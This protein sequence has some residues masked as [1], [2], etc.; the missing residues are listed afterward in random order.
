[1]LVGT[2]EEELPEEILLEIFRFLDEIDL[3]GISMVCKRWSILSKSNLLWTDVLIKNQLLLYPVNNNNFSKDYFEDYIKFKEETNWIERKL[4]ASAIT[5]LV[6]Y[7]IA[8]SIQ[9]LNREYSDEID[10]FEETDGFDLILDFIPIEIVGWINLITI[11]L[12]ILSLIILLPNSYRF[13]KL[14]FLIKKLIFSSKNL[15]SK[16]FLF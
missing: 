6:F 3:V 1:M 14:R 13:I 2:V 5:G 9:R 16:K 8:K 7:F 11:I 12:W 10:I 4:Q 15:I